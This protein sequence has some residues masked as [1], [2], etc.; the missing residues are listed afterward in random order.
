VP[1]AGNIDVAAELNRL[2]RAFDKNEKELGRVAGKLNNPKFVDKAPDDVIEKEK[3][4]L[5]DFESTSK[6]LSEQ[7]E[8][9]KAL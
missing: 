2:T 7:I 4:K 8:A 5:A 3:A 9:I 6:K 1:M